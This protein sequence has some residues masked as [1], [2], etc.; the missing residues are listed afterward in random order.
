MQTPPMQ[1]QDMI[2]NKLKL[3]I[4][5]VGSGREKRQFQ[6]EDLLEGIIF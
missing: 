6:R 4:M 1:R 3:K 2:R 5:K